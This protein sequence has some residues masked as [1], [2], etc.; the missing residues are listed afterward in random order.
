MQ[1][2]SPPRSVTMDGS[3]V[4]VTVASKDVKRLVKAAMNE[5]AENI[6]P[7]L[8]CGAPSS[9]AE[10]SVDP[11]LEAVASFCV[12]VPATWALSKASLDFRVG[13]GVSCFVIVL[14][15]AHLR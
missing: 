3:A 6:N 10:A 4:E 5:M 8:N 12:I 14:T 7:F 13:K 15:G 1:L 9:V 11:R 2:S